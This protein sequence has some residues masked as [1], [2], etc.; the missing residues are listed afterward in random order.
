MRLCVSF[1]A[2][3]F[4]LGADAPA[5][6]VK[7]DMTLLEGDWSLVSGERDGQTIPEEFVKTG[8]RSVKD[9]E[10]SVI[11][12]DM[13]VMKAKFKIDPIKKPKTIDYTVTDGPE[14]GKTVLGI[15]E[16]DGDTVKFCFSAPDKERPSEFTA[17]EGSGRTLSLWKRNKK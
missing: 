3:L 7:K 4:L 13:V 1:V 17:K 16:L 12:N 14:K 5:D 9:A 11:I 8:K 2:V 10:T 6:A 15:Y